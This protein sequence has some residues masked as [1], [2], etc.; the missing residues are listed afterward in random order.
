MLL[1]RG[2]TWS[3]YQA[4]GELLDSNGLGIGRAYSP[5]G[6]HVIVAELHEMDPVDGRRGYPPPS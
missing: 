2:I 3:D 1:I 6:L 4:V 5:E